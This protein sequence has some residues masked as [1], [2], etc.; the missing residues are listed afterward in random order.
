[1]Q[2]RTFGGL[3]IDG[4]P[5]ASSP[6]PAG[7]RRL[8]LLAVVAA[9]GP[10]GITREQI[11]GILWPESPE[12]QARHRLSQTLYLLRQETG[13]PWIT[14]SAQLRLDSPDSSDV[15]QFL[16]ALESGQP[17]RAA[18]LYTGPF[19]DGFYLSGTPEFERWVDQT[20]SRYRS[21]ATKALE[22]LARRAVESGAHGEACGWW[23]RLSGIEPFSSAYAAGLMRSHAAMGEAA[24]AVR[25]GREYESRVRH[26]L[27]AEPDPVVSALIAELSAIRSPAHPPSIEAGRIAESGQIPDAERSP[28]VVTEGT[29]EADGRDST[30]VAAGPGYSWSRGRLWIAALVAFTMV[31]A[32]LAWRITGSP[33]GSSPLLAI[34]AIQPRDEVAI[35]NVLRDMLATNIARIQGLQVVANSR[36]VEL[37]AR[38]PSTTPAAINDAARRAGATEIVEGEIEMIAG[39][40]VMTM[41]RVAL[42]T[43]VVIQGYTVRARDLYALT[44]SATT[45][46]AAD[47]N[48]DPPP[49]AVTAVRTGSAVAYALYEQGLRAY[50]HG[51]LPATARLMSAALER[52]SAFAMAA[53]YLWR[54]NW[55]ASRYDDAASLVPLVRRLTPRA[56]ERE[57]LWIEGMLAYAGAP[58]SEFLRIA[59][60]LARRFPDDPDGQVLLGRALYS[61]GDWAGAVSAFDRAVAIDSVSGATSGPLCRVCQA[62]Y[63]MATAMMWWDS[64]AGAERSMRRLIAF[65]PDDEA[66][67]TGL[68]ESLLRQGRRTEAEAAIA[69]GAQIS[70]MRADFTFYLDRDLIRSGR[71]DELEA[72]LVSQLRTAAPDA[73]GQMPW[74]LAISLRN[75]G[76]MREAREL[77]S[78]GRV[79]GSPVGLDGY[80]DAVTLAI[81]AMESGQPDE[82]AREFLDLVE[83]DRSST[84]EPGFKARNLSWHMALAGTALAAAGDTAAVLA[85]ADSVERIGQSSS[86]GRDLRLHHFLRG[87][88]LQ[89][90]N[91]HA[92]AVEAFRRSMFSLTD[93]YT[94]IN[95]EMARSLIELDRHAEA[96][97]VL[98]PAVRGGVDGGN[99]Y[100]THTE[101]HEALARAFDANGQADSASVHWAAVAR[102]WRRADSEFEA[103]YAYAAAR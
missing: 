27:E 14:G 48:L 90:A 26:E 24:V 71:L 59:R 4:S 72:R 1:M 17:E 6:L 3:W 15:T 78:D 58:L 76:R 63:E 21:S 30:E 51:D 39:G 82:A 45:A 19:L 29:A 67:W 43:G 16:T 94:R 101:L 91:R 55:D 61:A 23:R 2:L 41:R 7:P 88:V 83:A 85:L 44:D 9:A 56:A 13:R 68:V 80:A 33:T 98:Q 97:A 64:L 86:F 36:L 65:R 62:T 20:R 22:L 73:R 32:A 46:I 25:M 34:G 87:L 99:T 49:D 100:V 12:E 96:I 57:R 42:G 103:R 81:V 84:V 47:F 28:D 77:A 35:G 75:Q 93:G 74:L 95:L 11:I 69:R 54:S 70:G 31:A 53:A 60:E 50:F 8:A 89:R 52:D 79:P 40:Y 66:G 37:L 102:A 5:D 10:G 18:A 92:E 38:E